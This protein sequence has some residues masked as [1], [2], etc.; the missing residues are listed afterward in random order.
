MSTYS[1]NIGR[2][3]E[4]GAGWSHLVPSKEDR[5]ITRAIAS[6]ALAATTGEVQPFGWWDVFNEVLYRNPNDA[7][8]AA[9]GGNRIIPLFRHVPGHTCEDRPNLPCEACNVR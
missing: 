2:E 9:E 4:D 1:G 5:R 3:E 7:R 6:A 8:L